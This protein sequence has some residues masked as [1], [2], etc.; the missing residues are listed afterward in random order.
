MARDFVIEVLSNG[1]W[2][3]NNAYLL[4][5]ILIDAVYIDAI[6]TYRYSTHRWS[7]H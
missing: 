4:Q 2:H 6:D 7:T 1:Q 5:W 3:V